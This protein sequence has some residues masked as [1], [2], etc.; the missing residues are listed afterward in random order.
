VVLKTKK[1]PDSYRAISLCSS[2]LK[3]Y[4]QVI[5]HIV[6]SNSAMLSINQLQGDFQKNMS[7]TMTSFLVRKSIYF[8]Q[9]HNSELYSCFLDVRQCFDRV[10]HSVLLVKLFKTG[11]DR[12]IFKIIL[13]MF[14]NVYS[15]VKNMVQTSD[16]FPILQ[17]TRQGQSMNPR[18]Y[19][20]FVNDL[21]NTLQKSIY[22]FNMYKI[23][24]CCPTSALDMVLISMTKNGLSNLIHICYNNSLTER[25]LQ[26]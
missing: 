17:G 23:N 20:I 1:D 15:C 26:C 25:Y 11:I 4:E 9:E 21:M 16:W 10:S 24:I 12:N 19:L 18:L 6:D 3:L 5:S 13:N 2:I 14:E 22:G 7:C 8:A